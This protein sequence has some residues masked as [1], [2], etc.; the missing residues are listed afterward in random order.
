MTVP[1]IIKRAFEARL[2]EVNLG[3]RMRPIDAIMNVTGVLSDD[4]LTIDSISWT[5]GVCTFRVTGGERGK[6]YPVLIQFTTEG[7]PSQTLEA[8]IQLVIAHG[9]NI[10]P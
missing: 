8:E 10:P 3:P 6:E 1:T 2:F 4:A 7:D 9:S 5:A